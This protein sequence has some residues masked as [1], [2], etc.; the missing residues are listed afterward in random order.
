MYLDSTIVPVVM[1]ALSEVVKSRP[2]KPLE[3]IAYYMLKHNPENL[4]EEEPVA[5]A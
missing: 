2:D 1:Q 5:V 4:R 3:W